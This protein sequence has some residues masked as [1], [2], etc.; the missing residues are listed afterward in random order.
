MLTVLQHLSTCKTVSVELESLFGA[1]L[2]IPGGKPLV[3]VNSAL[4]TVE[5]LLVKEWLLSAVMA[6][7]PLGDIR[8][9]LPVQIYCHSLPLSQLR[10]YYPP[11]QP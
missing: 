6:N 7:L 8:W 4:E 10:Q 3:V 9:A 5:Q 1:F 11:P 2:N